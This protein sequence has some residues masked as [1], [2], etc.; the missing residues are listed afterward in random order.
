MFGAGLRPWKPAREIV[1]WTIP[2]ES[3][4]GRVKPLAPKTVLRIYAG[5]VRFA[6]PE[7]YL[8]LLRA[9][10]AAR[11]IPV[12]D[13]E[14]PKRGEAQPFTFPL[15][16]G[17]ERCRGFRPVSDPLGTVTATG[18]DLGLVEPF[19]LPQR[20]DAPAKP[21]EGPVPTLTTVARVALV[22]PFVATLRHSG[23]RDGIARSR[24]I[25]EPL[26]TVCAGGGHM[27]LVEPFVLSQGAGGAP[28]STGEPMPTIPTRGAHEL[29][30]PYH[31]RSR[32][33]SVEAPLPTAT[34]RDRFALVTAAFGERKGQRARV[35]S[36]D[37]PV[38][39]VCAQGRVPLVEA[40]EEPV[41]DIR[42]R[43][44]QPRELARAMGFPSGYRFPAK[45]KDATRMTGNAVAVHTAEALVASVMGVRR[46]D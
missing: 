12:P 17:R 30:V 27:A 3:I 1:D 19:M 37:E 26:P 46:G 7:P 23:T 33:S 14:R 36:V 28:R 4:F 24:T 22:E 18:T 9:H 29:V 41:Y 35:R 10:M 11:G 16:Q 42:M 45:K 21:I 38:P 40:C 6:W 8:E 44:L 34:T 43:M 20:N 32:C 39:T 13:L 31:G 2:G 5:A 15:N 25:A